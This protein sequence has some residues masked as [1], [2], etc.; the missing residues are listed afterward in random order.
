MRLSVQGLRDKVVDECLL[1]L[2]RISWW[3]HLKFDRLDTQHK[4]A[5][6]DSNMVFR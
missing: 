4:I 3:L 2:I 6:V 1:G 5:L